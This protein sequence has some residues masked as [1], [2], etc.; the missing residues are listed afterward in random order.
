MKLK[1]R[2]PKDL[3]F[4]LGCGG[5][6]KG[7]GQ[8]MGLGV[9]SLQNMKKIGPIGSSVDKKNTTPGT[10]YIYFA[11]DEAVASLVVELTKMRLDMAKS[12]KGVHTKPKKLGITINASNN[13]ANGHSEQRR[14][15]SGTRAKR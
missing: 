4:I 6:A 7:V 9:V 12:I 11:T 10:A 13:S 3:T 8:I 1:K 2:N 14:K 15:V 5:T